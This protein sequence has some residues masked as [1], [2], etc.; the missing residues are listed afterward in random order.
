[1]TTYVAYLTGSGDIRQVEARLDTVQFNQFKFQLTQGQFETID[2]NLT[3]E[4][5]DILRYRVNGGNVEEK[6]DNRTR[7]VVEGSLN[8]G[9]NWG[10]VPLFQ[11]E[12]GANLLIRFRVVDEN[13]D[14]VDTVNGDFF[15][16]LPVTP[17]QF[18]KLTLTAGISQSLT[19]DTSRPGRIT[20]ASNALLRID[21]P[22]TIEIYETT[23]LKTEP[24]E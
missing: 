15:M 13:G 2:G 7:V 3:F 5:T 6:P 10:V 19:L 22:V 8:A 23:T 1:M 21:Q 17:E 12:V 16:K 18:L 14:T 4:G 24:L 9:A 11:T 20:I